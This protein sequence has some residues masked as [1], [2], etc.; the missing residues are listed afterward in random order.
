MQDST[1]DSSRRLGLLLKGL[2]NKVSS[3]QHESH[4]H[5][6]DTPGREVK[7]VFA[8]QI[9]HQISSIA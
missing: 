9:S 2:R 7:L 5:K 3:I 1:L 4:W 8:E 6:A